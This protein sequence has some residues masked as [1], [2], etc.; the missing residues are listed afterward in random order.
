[1]TQ[2]VVLVI[3][4]CVSV[5]AHVWLYWWMKFK[6]DEGAITRCLKDSDSSLTS[7]VISSRVSMNVER[8]E[9]LCNKSQEIRRDGE[10][11]SLN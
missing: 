9:R 7:K 1:M 4:I 5:G 8:V 6:M 2:N 11:F 3:V 10:N